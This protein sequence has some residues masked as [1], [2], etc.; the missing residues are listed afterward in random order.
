MTVSLFNDSLVRFSKAATRAIAFCDPLETNK[1]W[2]KRLHF[3]EAFP[4]ENPTSGSLPTK[5]NSPYAVVNH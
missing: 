4:A 2:S 5:H 3:G 1:H